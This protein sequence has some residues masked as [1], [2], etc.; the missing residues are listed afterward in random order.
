[1]D[2]SLPNTPQENVKFADDT[3]LFLK[4]LTTEKADRLVNLY[5]KLK[6]LTGLQINPV[7]SNYLAIGP[8]LSNEFSNALTMLAAKKDAIE[9]LGL[10]LSPNLATAKQLTFEKM[11]TAMKSKSKSFA[12]SIGYFHENITST[13]G[14][15]QTFTLLKSLCT[16]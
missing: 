1:M 7:K 9:H 3:T 12:A 15:V 5:D 2:E 6:T 11:E 14:Y 8:D 4:N 13:N 16:Q 10:F